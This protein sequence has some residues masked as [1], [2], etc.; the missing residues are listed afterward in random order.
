[1]ANWRRALAPTL[2]VGL[3]ALVLSGC[4]RPMSKSP[5]SVRRNNCN[6]V[7]DGSVS[8]TALPPIG[9][10]GE[11]QGPT[12]V[13]PNAAPTESPFGTPADD[14]QTANAEGSFGVLQ[15]VGALPNS[16]GRD[17]AGGLTVDKLLGGWTMVSGAD[18]CQ[19]NLTQ[20]HQERHRR[21]IRASAPACVSRPERGG[22]L[23]IGWQPGAAVRRKWRHDRGADPVR[24]PLHRHAE[25][26]HGH[27]DGG[28][29]TLSLLDAMCWRMKSA[30]P[31]FRFSCGRGS[32]RAGALSADPLQ[33][34]AARYA[35]PD[36]RRAQE[37]ARLF[38]RRKQRCGA[39][40]WSARSGAARPC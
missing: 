39:P 25:R 3:V 8:T 32:G 10:N 6:P 22:E 5:I 36:R 13:D 29:A 38:G 24:Q 40:I 33:A 12:P 23:A 35:R 21:A 2:V 26:R 31:Q 27:L 15:P 34:E 7:Q 17:L 19:L 28:L 20:T 9:P 18:Q 1:M 14:A 37:T 11:V 4:A 16:S 30:V